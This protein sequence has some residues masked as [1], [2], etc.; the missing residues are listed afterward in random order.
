[1]AENCKYVRET[2][3]VPACIGRRV[4]VY[5]KSGIIAADHGHYIGVNFDADKVTQIKSAHPTD[6]V[7]YGEMGKVRPLTRSQRRYLD[8]LDVADLF[9][10][11]RAYLRYLSKAKQNV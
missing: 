9:D 2:Y 4:T 8:Y 7:V 10:G 5:G 6:G 1:M 11:F 3:G